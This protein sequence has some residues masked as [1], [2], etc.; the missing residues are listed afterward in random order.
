MQ[1][2]N[3]PPRAETPGRG[4]LKSILL[5]DSQFQFDWAPVLTNYAF[6]KA[7]EGK[8][9]LDAAG[10]RPHV[11]IVSRLERVEEAEGYRRFHFE[12]SC[13]MFLA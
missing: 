4:D 10:R 9:F 13:M 7:S 8:E 5:R 3:H 12:V 6:R 11:R 1:F 2:A